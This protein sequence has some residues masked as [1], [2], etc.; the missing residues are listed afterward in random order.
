VLAA[1]S[2]LPR[3]PPFWPPSV[4]PILTVGAASADVTGDISAALS[5]FAADVVGGETFTGTVAA[6]LSPFAA[7]ATGT[8]GAISGSMVAAFAP[9]A[10]AGAGVETFAGTAAAALSPLAAAAAGVGSRPSPA[11]PPPR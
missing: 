4:L 5:P 1:W 10:A 6:A 7:D 3:L 9:L 2:P 8:A 11:P